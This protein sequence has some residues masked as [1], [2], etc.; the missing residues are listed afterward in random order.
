MAG[1]IHYMRFIIP[2][3]T[4]IDSAG[5]GM[6]ETVLFTV[7]SSTANINGVNTNM[8][9]PCRLIGTSIG[10]PLS[11]VEHYMSG[12]TV[13]YEKSDEISLTRTVVEDEN[14]KDKKQEEKKQSR[15]PSG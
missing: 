8:T 1:S 5:S 10:C 4:E 7:G 12:V 13:K 11:F 9:G 15:S 14:N 3:E 2:S 6:E